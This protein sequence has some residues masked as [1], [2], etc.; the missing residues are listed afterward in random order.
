MRHVSTA[1]A[2]AGPLVAFGYLL[3]SLAYCEVERRRRTNR[4]RRL[5]T[6]SVVAIATLVATT[7]SYYA[8]DAVAPRVSV[9]ALAVVA[10]EALFAWESVALW[11]GVAAVLGHA[12][13]VW[14]GFRGGSGVAPAAIVAFVYLPV[15][16]VAAA[17]AWFTAMYFSKQPRLPVHAAMA[18]ALLVSWLAWVTGWGQS[19]GGGG[20]GVV[21]GPEST[22]VVAAAAGIVVARAQADASRQRD[23]RRAP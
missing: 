18:A 8:I 20:W 16:L 1:A 12:A 21:M 15:V 2:L 23:A 4:E 22:L 14:N 17:A 10:P 7:V 19:V 6:A 11:T 3:T 5:P 9:S 13:P